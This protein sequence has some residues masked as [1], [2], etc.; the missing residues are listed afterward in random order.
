MAIQSWLNAPVTM[1]RRDIISAAAGA[2]AGSVF[3]SAIIL[4][5]ASKEYHDVIRIQN[6]TLEVQKES[7]NFLLMHAP[8]EVH[9]ELNAK[10]DF[11][12][13]IHGMPTEVDGE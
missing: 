5:F 6:L 9:A 4:H 12:R 1:T 7:I 2:F 8:D 11:W 3:G 13:V 10:L